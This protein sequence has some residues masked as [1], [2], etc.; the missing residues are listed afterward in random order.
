MDKIY[1]KDWWTRYTAEDKRRMV[2]KKVK[3]TGET[4]EDKNNE[5]IIEM[6]YL[7][8]CALSSSL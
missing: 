4:A 2:D 3:W 7:T 1:W 6:Y 8:G 5:L